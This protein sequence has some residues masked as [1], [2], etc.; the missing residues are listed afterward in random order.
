M[1][2]A[3]PPGKVRA[4]ARLAL[5]VLSVLTAVLLVAGALGVAGH[6]PERGAPAPAPRPV[7]ERPAPRGAG[8]APPAPVS[9][10]EA[11]LPE[12]QA[13]V[14]RERGLTFERPV[15]VT[16]LDDEAFEQRLRDYEPEDRE[17]LEHAQVVLQAVGLLD[18][19]VDLFEIEQQFV[20]AAVLGFYDTEDEDLVVRGAEATPLVR[21]TLV[22]ELVHALE[23]QR[24]GL[25]R[26]ELG[27][28]ATLGLQSLAEGSAVR[29]EERY[30]RTMS[31]RERAEADRADLAQSLKVPD[32]LPD[33][34]RVAFGFPYAYGPRLVDA[35]LAAG[36]QRRLDA[37][38]VRP[39]LS[40]EQVLDPRKYLAGDDPKPVP[41]PPADRPPF[42]D[43]EVG[44]LFLALILDV[45]LDDDAAAEAA[46]GWG[47]DHYVAWKDGR[48]TC[49]RMQFVMDTPRDTAELARALG[50]W[51]G[52]RP[53]ASA[54]GT[55]L[56]TCG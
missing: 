36:G 5:P 17:E 50:D 8:D 15:K 38:F 25:D 46:R 26:E 18:P 29:I 3:P 19:G 53:G 56:T 13:F 24:F 45:E 10:V 42:D 41:A 31:R 51:A 34:V 14:E 54:S 44:E 21:T 33:V 28:E 2:K 49:V 43:G 6:E 37:A 40:S 7:G 48:R 16:L 22:H 11:V 30:R 1:Q 35:I 20:A 47:G 4:I 52:R 27:D 23:D 39:P 32:D 55:S 12:L 9:P